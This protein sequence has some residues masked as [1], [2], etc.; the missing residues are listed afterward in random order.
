PLPLFT[1]EF[2]DLGGRNDCIVVA[3]DAGAL[4]LASYCSREL[5]V[6]T[7]FAAKFRPGPEEVEYDEIVGRFSGKKT[8]LILDDI[9]SSGGTVETLIR[10][11]VREKGIKE[12]RLGISHNLCRD[13]ALQR[14]RELHR[15]YRL[16]QVVVTDS[17]PQPEEYTALPFFSV[18]SLADTFCRVVN[19]LHL[20]RSVSE[21]FPET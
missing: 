14:L 7:A 16:R 21:L 20:S 15:D 2:R 5:G 19:R 13:E 10:L 11:L 17:V 6:S 4:K 1:E 18:R 12:V 9:L 3:P 8:A